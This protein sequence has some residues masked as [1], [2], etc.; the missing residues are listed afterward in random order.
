MTTEQLKTIGFIELQDKHFTG[1]KE[2]LFI[3]LN[4]L[5]FNLGIDV[6]EKTIFTFE[7]DRSSAFPYPI[8]AR[9]IQF[10]NYPE[11]AGE[12]S[13]LIS[14]IPRDKSAIKLNFE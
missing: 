11:S 2:I 4:N 1:D 7:G 13:L 10:F 3:P 8:P 6:T 9:T 14:V 5:G 12:L